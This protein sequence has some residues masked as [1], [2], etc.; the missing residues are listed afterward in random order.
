MSTQREYYA[1]GWPRSYISTLPD[2]T[3]HGIY[4][5]WREDGSQEKRAWYVSGTLHGEYCE[6]AADGAATTRVWYDH[7]TITY[8]FLTFQI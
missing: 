2:G 8:N 3:L 4:E 6:W 7:G 5:T 1:N